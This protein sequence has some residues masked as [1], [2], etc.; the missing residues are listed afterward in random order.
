L[1]AETPKIPT[2]FPVSLREAAWTWGRL[3]FMHFWANAPL[4]QLLTGL[5][6]AL[7][8]VAVERTGQQ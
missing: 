2:D 6:A 7:G 5:R 4:P 1:N 8:H 3:F